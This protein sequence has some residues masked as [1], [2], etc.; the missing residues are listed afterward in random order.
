VPRLSELPRQVVHGDANDYN[1][2]V[3]SAALSPLQDGAGI[4]NAVQESEL[5][6]IG[7][8]DFGDMVETAR[9]CNL[10]SER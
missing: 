8:F 4:S 2:L 3:E 5:A 1:V 9:V 6:G 7:V 10:V